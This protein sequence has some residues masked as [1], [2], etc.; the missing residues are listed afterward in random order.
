MANKLT[1]A[2]LLAEITNDPTGLGLPALYAI[3]ND[4]GIANLLNDPTSVGKGTVAADDMPKADFETLVK[5]SEADNITTAQHA[6]LDF[7][8][9]SDLVPIGNPEMQEAMLEIFTEGTFP[10]THPRM[11]AAFTR[12]GSRAEVLKGTGY[13]VTVDD[14]SATRNS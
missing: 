7:Y 14:V 4:S 3:G 11:V 5:G 8:M 1:N 6:V 2:E 13:R 10:L 12:D 9:N